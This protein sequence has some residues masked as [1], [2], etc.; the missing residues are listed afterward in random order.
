MAEVFAGV[1]AATGIFGSVTSILGGNKAKK[2]ARKAAAA[3]LKLGQMNA[4]GLRS[5]AV[6]DQ[7]DAL[8]AERTLYWEA[9]K[10]RGANLALIAGSGMN[11]S[12]GSAQQARSQ[13]ALAIVGDAQRMRENASRRTQGTLHAAKIARLGGQSQAAGLR[14]QGNAALMSGVGSGLQGLASVSNILSS[15][16]S[17][18]TPSTSTAVTPGQTAVTPMPLPGVPSTTSFS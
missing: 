4:E 10:F 12:F 7:V 14:A 3:A 16:F 6:S 1:G 13:N 9:A 8:Q 2:A 15:A 5:L 17:N 11:S 18:Q